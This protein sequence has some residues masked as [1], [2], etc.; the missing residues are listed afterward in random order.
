MKIKG[1]YY[2]NAFGNEE[3]F[4]EESPYDL[5]KYVKL[6]GVGKRSRYVYLPH[7]FVKELKLLE[8][9]R[10]KITLRDKAIVIEKFED[11]EE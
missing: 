11:E 6:Q 7:E 10:V 1:D 5:E 8:Q 3:D 4:F 2:K 9:K